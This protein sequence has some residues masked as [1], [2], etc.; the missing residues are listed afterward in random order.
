V[1][2]DALLGP[3]PAAPTEE[4]PPRRRRI[5]LSYVLLAASGALFV[6]AAV[7]A[8]TGADDLTS[9]GAIR[10]GLQAAVP[11]GLAGLGG[12]W[13]ERAGVVNIGLEGQLILGTWFGAWGALEWGPWAGV[14]TAIAGGALG[15]L[16]HA[17]ATVT[18][19]VDHIISGV[20]ITIL[21]GGAA[22]YLSSLTFAGM[23]GGGV[24]QSPSVG[25]LPRLSVPGVGALDSIEARQWFAVSDIAGLLRGVLTGTSV[26]TILAIALVPATFFVLWRTGFGLRLRSV[27]ENPRA[28]ESLGVNVYLYKYYGV[29]MSGALAG[30]GGGFLSM[31]ASSIY[32]EGQTGGRGF[33]GL[34]AMI[35]GNWRP[36]GLAA[37]AML[38]GY[39]D[40]LQLRRGSESVHALLLLVAV[41]LVAAA[42]WQWRRRGYVM[43]GV[44]LA[45]AALSV[46]WYFGTDAIP[47]PLVQA[48]PHVTTLVVLALASQRLR[49]PAAD[50]LPYRKGAG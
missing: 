29:V 28:A 31:V 4:R 44:A 27:G 26:L 48:A 30:L 37:G 16:L 5:R 46:L 3:T 41:L 20:A 1:T 32:R 6:L 34:A 50:G 21:A 38:F 39:I 18:F 22:R 45:M 13:S 25:E 14:L 36:G 9:D 19:R 33:I 7:R 42:V 10:A 15:G 47:V 24:T 35:F 11:L 49:P 40:A 23:P 12:L 43:A 17:V 8:L 2:A